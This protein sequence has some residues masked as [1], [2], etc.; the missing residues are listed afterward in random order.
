[1]SIILTSG[2][3]AA[4]K[5]RQPKQKPK[6]VARP[7]TAMPVDSYLPTE[8]TAVWNVRVDGVHFSV[9][10][11]KDTLEVWCNDQLME[12]TDDF[13]DMGSTV[14]FDLGSKKARIWILPG[15]RGTKYK[16]TLDGATVAAAKPPRQLPLPE[17]QQLSASC[18]GGASFGFS[19]LPE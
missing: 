14:D 13:S 10:L 7:R 16:F 9:A 19:E 12:T 17:E 5:L 18:E 15:P 11:S 1:M 8:E 4:S 6:K 3:S 2:K